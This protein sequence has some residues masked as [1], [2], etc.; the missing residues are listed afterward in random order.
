[1]PAEQELIKF[2]REHFIRIDL[3]KEHYYYSWGVPGFEICLEPCAGG[4]DV[5]IYDGGKRLIE[6]GKCTDSDGYLNSAEA[7]FGDRTLEDWN[8]A[9][10]I[11]DELL[12]KY[13]KD[14]TSGP[15]SYT[16][17]MEKIRELLDQPQKE[18]ICA[19]YTEGKS[20]CGNKHS[21]NT[22]F[23]Y[24]V[25]CE[26]CL[27]ILSQ[28][29]VMTCMF[30]GCTD[31]NACSGGCSWIE[32]NVCSRCKDRVKG[33]DLI[34]GQ[35]IK[36]LR[37]RAKT[38]TMKEGLRLT[39]QGMFVPVIPMEIKSG[40]GVSLTII[41]N[42]PDKNPIEIFS[43]GKVR[44]MPDPADSESIATAVLGKGYAPLPS[45]IPSSRMVHF[46]KRRT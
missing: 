12:E 8:K 6:P 11:A 13:T 41:E 40:Y 22:L 36:A 3:D 30:C 39:M 20:L 15:L 28:E 38:V 1:M 42:I 26:D 34:F 9:L 45:L 4:F 44:G 21:M 29:S 25:T 32:P 35:E 7:M 2:K 24:Q 31:N 27:R 37:A 14:N 19:C 33:N 43:V 23:H 16:L 17:S 5:R 46:F 10:A 18:K